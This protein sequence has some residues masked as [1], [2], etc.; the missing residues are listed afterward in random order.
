VSTLLLKDVLDLAD[1][2]D[3]PTPVYL[4]A[5]PEARKVYEHFNFESVQGYDMQMIRWGPQKVSKLGE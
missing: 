5:L 2:T 4:E 1:A 3:P